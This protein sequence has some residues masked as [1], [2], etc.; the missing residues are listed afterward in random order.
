MELFKLFGTI[1]VNNSEANKAIDETTGNAEKAE[2]K[3]G[4]VFSGIGSA[5]VKIGTTVA[6]GVGAAA[7]GLGVLIKQ[8]VTAYSDYEQLVGGVETLFKDSSGKV[9]EYANNAYKTAGLSA[10]QYMDTVTS[11]SAS[12]LQGLGGDTDKAAES[13]NLAITDMADNANK[14]G[15]SMDLIQNAYQG[16]AK[17]NYTMLDNLKLGYGGT[18]SE[19]ARLIN[20]SGVLGDTMKVTADN[21]NEVSFDK[22]IEAIHTVQTN[23]GITGTTSKE[24]AATIQGS[25]GMMKAAWE[26]F[27]TGMADPDQDFDA[28]LGNLVDSV[29][30]VADNLI[31]RIIETVPRLV[32]GLSGLISTLG[33]YMPELLSTLLPAILEGAAQLLSQVV[34]GIP[35]LFSAVVPALIESIKMILTTAVGSSDMSSAFDG[36]FSSGFVE[37]MAEW[38]PYLEDTIGLFA[39]NTASEFAG[40]IG[41]VGDMFTALGTVIQPLVETVLTGLVNVFDILLVTWNDVLLPAISLVIDIFTQLVTT[42]AE[43]VAPAVQTISDKFQELQQYVT[44]AIENY[45]LPVISSFIDMVRQLWEENQDK[46]NLIGELFSTVFNTI[47]GIVSWF[48]DTFKNYIYPFLAWLCQIV[49]S[50]MDNIRAVFQSVFDLIGGIVQFFVALFKGDWEGMWE[51]IKTILSSAK[52]IVINLFNLLASVLKSIVNGIKEK[53]TEIFGKIK[54]KLIEIATNIKEKVKEKFEELKQKITDTVN[55]MKEKVTSLF[56]D[57]KNKMHEKVKEAKEKVLGVFTNIKTGITDK[58]NGAKEAVKEAIDKIK[59]FFNF[60]WKL[61]HLKLP[62]FHLSGGFNLA[63]WAE[64]RGFPAL[65]V[66]W[67]AKAMD[68]PMLLTKPT[69]FGMNAN[70]QIMAGGEAGNEVVSGADTLMNMISAAVA[71]KNAEVVEVLLRILDALTSIDG[72]VGDSIRE[73]FDGVTCRVDRREFAR[74]VNEVM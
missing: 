33:T 73:A 1:A 48:V 65:S 55:G 28:L 47:A 53:L 30:T 62:H 70:G 32:Q 66:E 27:L 38:L 21:V 74:L 26:N 42:I 25:I 63:E 51:A 41:E 16:F 2:G 67:Y 68:N 13:A 24:A 45:I 72:S 29:I 3:F 10:N 46:I 31:P 35:A 43:A 5:A 8:S 57:M 7:T 22:M 44:A 69:A 9:L 4:K 58:I 50:N 34:T 19:M 6:A 59:G 54:D 52:D 18:A 15:T 11:F 17:Q 36:I 71:E 23:M 40:K 39:Q 37:K 20:D 56:T 64:G 60:E 49:Q 12:L 61:P 14:M